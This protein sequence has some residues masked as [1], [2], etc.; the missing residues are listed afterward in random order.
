VDTLV[1]A[2]DEAGVEASWNAA[3]DP[4][5]RPLFP[6]K[7]LPHCH[8]QA[9][10]EAFRY[11]IDRLHAGGRPVLS[12]Y[13]LSQCCALIEEHPDWAMEFLPV[14]GVKPNPEVGRH[15]VCYNSPYGELLP[16]FAV[17]V[18][19]DL[20]FDGIYFDGSTMSNHGTQPIFQPGCICPFCRERFRRDTG[21]TIP[22][23]VD[24]E[25]DDFR[26]WVMWRYDVLMEVW[27]RVV[28]AVHAVKPEAAILFNNY[29]RRALPTYGWSTAIPL[30]RLNLDAIMGGELD[31]F[32]GQADFQ[33]KYN[34]AYACSQGVE[35]WWSL[36]NYWNLW[37]PDI[38]ALPARQAML[39]GMA[40]GGGVSTGV[41]APVAMVVDA[42]RGMQ[43]AG[44]TLSAFRD[45]RPVEYAAIWC[46][47]ATQDFGYRDRADLAYNEMHGANE[48]CQQ[49]HLLSGVVFDDQVAAGDL[50]QYPV[51]LA[52]N[53]TSISDDQARQVR[54]YVEKGGVLL[55]THETG[56][57]DEWGRPREQPV[58]DDLLGIASRRP[59]DG[60][61][62]LEFADPALVG[63]VGRW[64]SFGGR[65]TKVEPVPDVELLARV[66]DRTEGSWDGLET[67]HPPFERTPNLWRRRVGRG[68]VV[69]TGAELF[70][71]HL[72][73]PVPRTVR[74]FQKLLTALAVPPVTADAPL[75][76]TLNAR[77]ME[78]GR[79][80][81][82][83]H[84]APGTMFRYPA[85]MWSNYTHNVGELPVWSDLVVRLAGWHC[86]RAESGV[87]GSAFVVTGGHEI[88]IPRLA[89]HEVVLA[90]VA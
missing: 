6:S 87:T 77:R 40:A 13:S 50:A 23:R 22:A 89:S 59:S 88:R 14:E 86:R 38:E 33:V 8:P 34:R 24:F 19:R 74:F 16:R 69:Y 73:E 76:V 49:A 53:I 11:L 31:T 27:R 71:R 68:W 47:Q 78:D 46:S 7:V 45:G 70:S 90:E 26:H 17:E 10:W 44:R 20:G 15:S 63:A 18:V 62:T 39:G 85:P 5:G 64:L 25:N 82:V 48:L 60:S 52:P 67:G 79:L 58:L 61:P 21:R 32:P 72:A 28:E 2:L 57:R 37:C 12:W 84:N 29:R 9:S 1:A 35:T 80:A 30:R 75:C 41:G 66:A 65:F 54:R 42:L 83:L 4:L 55:A 3:V 36:A 81:I 56:C 43:D 51:L